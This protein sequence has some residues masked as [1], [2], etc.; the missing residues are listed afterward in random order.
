VSLQWL[1]CQPSE[2]PDPAPNPST[3]LQINVARFF[4]YGLLASD[5]DNSPY[6]Q[7]GERVSRLAMAG[8]R[9]VIDEFRS[10]V[11]KTRN[12]P[13]CLVMPTLFGSVDVLAAGWGVP[14]MGRSG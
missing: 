7:A 12:Y 2:V 1:T 10:D 14:V 5:Y 8:I 4:V 13:D 6:T 9:L 3:R 11:T